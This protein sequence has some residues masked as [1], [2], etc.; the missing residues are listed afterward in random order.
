MVDPLAGIPGIPPNPGLMK[1]PNVGLFGSDREIGLC[2]AGRHACVSKPQGGGPLP[3]PG[4]SNMKRSDCCVA[5]GLV[6]TSPSVEACGFHSSGG[7]PR[8]KWAAVDF[9]LGACRLVST[10]FGSADVPRHR[11]PRAVATSSLRPGLGKGPPRLGLVGAFVERCVKQIGLPGV[12]HNKTTCKHPE[13]FISPPQTPR[14][15]CRPPCSLQPRCGRVSRP[16][17]NGRPQVSYSCENLE[18][19]SAVAGQPAHA[20]P[21]PHQAFGQLLPQGPKG[22]KRHGESGPTVSVV[23]RCVPPLHTLRWQ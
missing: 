8:P 20:A 6:R 13:V 21:P 18:F 19:Y 1:M 16:A 22:E 5:L 15:L 12:A 17:H 14:V 7:L 4:R 3:S 2:C 10:R 9:G 23:L 11:I